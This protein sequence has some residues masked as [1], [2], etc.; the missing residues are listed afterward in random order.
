[1]EKEF[2]A[3]GYY[4][5]KIFRAEG[6]EKPKEKKTKRGKGYPTGIPSWRRHILSI[7]RGDRN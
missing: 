5:R 2:K 4:E 1:M 3:G 7:S 6:E